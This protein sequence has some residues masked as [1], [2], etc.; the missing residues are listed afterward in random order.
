MKI[1]T[2]LKLLM[3]LA[4]L[5]FVIAVSL[6]YWRD[7][8]SVQKDCVLTTPKARSEAQ[9]SNCQPSG[10]SGAIIPGVI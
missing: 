2:V 1:N 8:E 4:G 7:F 5:P 3:L 9:R 10:F 6:S